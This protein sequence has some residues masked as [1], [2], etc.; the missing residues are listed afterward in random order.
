[1]PGV[2]LKLYIDLETYSTVPIAHGIYRYAEEAIILLVAYAVDDGPVLVTEDPQEVR[3]LIDTAGTLVA[4]NSQFDRVILEKFGLVPPLDPRWVDTA[5]RAS[6]YSLPRGLDVLCELLKVSVDKAK[7]KAGRALIQIFCKPDRNG[8]RTLPTDA[9]AKWTQ[10]RDYAQMDVEAMR[11]LDKR[12]PTWNDH[13]QKIWLLDQKIN[14]RGMRVDVELAHAAVKALEK[15]KKRADREIQVSTGNAVGTAHQRDA[16]LGYIEEAYGIKIPDLQ[17]DTVA[18][19]M[20]DPDLPQEVKDLLVLRQEG[21]S[22][23]TAKYAALLRSVSK[24]G[25]LRGSL[26]YCGASRTGRWS[27]RI[28]QPQNLPRQI[29][30]ADN[31]IEAFKLGCADLLGP[32]SFLASQCVR[33]CICGDPLVVSDLS[34]IEG[35]MLAW[36]AGDERK[37]QMY[38]EGRD[39]YV[40]TYA[41]TFGVDTARVTSDERQLGKTL[42]L[43]MGY[44]GGVSA[45]LTFAAGYGVDLSALVSSMQTKLPIF[46]RAA[47]ERF[48]EKSRPR[49]PKEIFITCDAIKRAWREANPLTVQLWYDVENAVREVL[50]SVAAI[51]VGKCVIDRSNRW[52]RIRLP[53]GRYAS[54][55]GC[56]VEDGKIVYRGV[57][58]YTRKWGNITT[59][60]G[61]LVEN[62]T[63]AASRDVL[64]DAMLAA[65]DAGLRP[66]LTVHD[67]VV[68]ESA[69]LDT[70]NKILATTP[71]WAPGLPLA[72]KGYVSTRYRK[73]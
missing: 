55:P 15:D 1:L 24:D 14:A 41:A 10:F 50:S 56:R 26:E 22:T 6:R 21:C 66:V 73:D 34:S 60:G 13:E 3:P 33:G 70:L 8:R 31:A 52:L 47:A 51:P 17:A 45:F 65:E 64:A 27:G 2:M 59:W 4:H 44:G 61:K 32:V 23:S 37:L 53:S 5:V 62:M 36:L 54:Y 71:T 20:A 12:L 29:I 38:R 19:R 43:A 25:R 69:D 67:E 57:D 48:Y 7:D 72:A 18:R 16:I 28:F 35:R 58:S 11:E 9:P 42:E 40:E 39:V 30:D 63:Q 46:H 68:G 49:I